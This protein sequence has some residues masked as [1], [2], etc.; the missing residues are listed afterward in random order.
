MAFVDVHCHLNHDSLMSRADEV[1][2]RAKGAGVARILAAGLNPATNRQCLALAAQ[3]PDVVRAS[4]GLYP[5]DALGLAPDESGILSEGPFDVDEALGYIEQNQDSVT[6]IGEVGMDF[7]Y[8]RREAEQR[9][10]F[11][12]VID[13]AERLKKPVI[14]HTRKAE[15]ECIELLES[16]KLKG[17]VLHCFTGRKHLIRKAA[18]LGFS[19]S[20]PPIIVKLQ[21]FQD[22]AGMV[23]VSQLLT[24][25]DS[26]WM[27]PV[28]GEVNEPA[29]VVYCVKKIAEVKGLDEVEARNLI[30][31]NYQRIFE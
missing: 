30:Y 20:I 4:L 27:S 15:L 23:P 22:L 2:G 14:V 18:D 21:Q 17:V 24:E 13:L 26:P 12:K 8:V 7:K 29:N 28:P 3:Y 16:S 19:F 9:A 1:V 6:A 5:V 25:T 31:M 11:Q 10:N